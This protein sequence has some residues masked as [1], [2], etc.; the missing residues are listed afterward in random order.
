MPAL[1]FFGRK[2]LIASDDLVFPGL[3]EIVLRILWLSL[4]VVVYVKYYHL[5][6]ACS[7]GGIFVR[8][9]ILGMMALLFLIIL[10]VIALVNRSAKGSISDVHARRHV[11][12]LLL[13]KLFLIIPETIINVFGTM[14]AFCQDVVVCPQESFVKAVIEALVVFNWV[15]FGLAIFVVVLVYDPLGSKKYSDL[16]E[17]PSTGE[18]LKHRKSTSLW[19][20]RFRW[21]F[22][23]VRSDEHGH[24]AFQQVAALLSSLFRSTDLVPSDILAGCVLLR[25][26]QKRETREMRRIYL[27]SDDE[28]KYST[29]VNRVFSMAPRWMNLE[30]AAHFLKLSM[31]A[32][33]WPFVMYQYC[34]TGTFRL[35]RKITCCACFTRRSTI[36]TDDNCCL[37]H[38]AGVKYISKLEEE[39]ILFASFRNHVFELPFCV[40]ADHKTC[41]IVIAIRG[42][43]SLRDIFT[44]LTAT[45]DKFEAAGVPPDTMAHKGMIIGANYILK[46]LDQAGVLEKAF[47]KYSDYGLVLTGHSLGAGVATLLAFKLRSR[48]SDLK[49][50]A[51]STP[52]GLISR[53]AAKVSESFVFTVGVG[54]DF[55]M[56]LGVDSVENLRTG[57]IQVLQAS[58]LPKYRILL[59]GF[60]YALFGVPPGDLEST[61]RD[62]LTA[63]GRSPLLGYQFIP[64]VAAS[65]EAALLS[66]NITVRRFSKAR[67]FTAGRILHIVSRK[68]TKSEKKHGKGGPSFEMRWATAEDFMELKVMPKMLV[69]HL[70]DNVYDTIQTVLNE[71]KEAK[72]DTPIA[73]P[74]PITEII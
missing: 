74:T 36:V 72:N 27:L 39:H 13:T 67:L 32:Y 66:R 41:N 35:L 5:T 69:D 17:S 58:R 11:P 45:S 6:W 59:N 43:I 20:R 56:R 73:P 4:I 38:L 15:L 54:D 22:C 3:L 68:K 52:A 44:D 31:A 21:A 55:V 71:Q 12:P 60:G 47:A 29:D 34:M 1:R 65:T 64:T 2:W 30:D 51:F 62:D 50:Y 7:H 40:I 16:Q 42:S 26:K 37:C 14:W 70:P 8:T 9:Y 24:E 63:P 23:W 46:R 57:I 18:S 49:V 19:Q 61:W 10:I 53:E 25:V 28:P 33:G 48:Y